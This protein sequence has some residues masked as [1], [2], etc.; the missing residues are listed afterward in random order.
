[1]SGSVISTEALEQLAAAAGEGSLVSH[2]TVL[3]DDVPFTVTLSPESP[4]ALRQVRENVSTPICV[5]E[6]LFTRYDFVPIFENRLADYI[7][8]DVVWTG[9]ITEI[10]KIASMAEA[11]Y[12]PISPHNAMGAIQVLAGAHAMMGVPTSTGWSLAWRHWRPTT[13]F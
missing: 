6:R 11:Y 9:G 10:R 5:G 4:E 7:M 8:P 3:V 1:M 2:E 13:L 12:I